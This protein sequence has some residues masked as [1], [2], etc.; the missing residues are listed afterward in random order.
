MTRPPALFRDEVDP[1]RF[2]PL[3]VGF[4]IIVVDLWR[5]SLGLGCLDQFMGWLLGLL[6][7]PLR[8]D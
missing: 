7:S 2:I 8:I 4:I 6:K 3:I 1:I 5:D